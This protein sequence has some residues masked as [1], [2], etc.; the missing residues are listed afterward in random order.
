MKKRLVPPVQYDT[1]EKYEKKFDESEIVDVIVCDSDGDQSDI[2][3]E[4]YENSAAHDSESDDDESIDG[5]SVSVS[6][7]AGLLPWVPR[8]VEYNR[9]KMALL[10]SNVNGF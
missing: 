10:T 7:N 3:E 1:G 8:T 6:N 2:E 5:G 9:S 4:Q